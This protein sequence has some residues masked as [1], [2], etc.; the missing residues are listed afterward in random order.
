MSALRFY[1]GVLGTLLI[2]S[3]TSFAGNPEGF[4]DATLAKALQGETVL[5]TLKDTGD[6]YHIFQRTYFANVSSDAYIELAVNHPKYVD[7]FDEVEAA[8][9]LSIN[10]DRTNFKYSLNLKVKVGFAT[11]YMDGEGEQKVT[12]APAPDEEALIKNTLVGHQDKVKHLYQNT[13]MIPYQGGILIEEELHLK[14]QKA[15]TT[16]TMIKNYL[17]GF[18]SRYVVA[19]R[20]E[21]GGEV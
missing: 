20:K 2:F 16:N 17:K 15:S 5:E 10:N 13:R 4:D 7:M 1:F 9:T 6:E 19:F 3:A 11:F 21:L 12:Y 8:Q 18:F 14:M